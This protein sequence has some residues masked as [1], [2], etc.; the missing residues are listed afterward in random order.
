[1]EKFFIV[2]EKSQLHK[3]Y[4][5]YEQ[6]RKEI[7]ERV[8]KFFNLAGIEA[9]EYYCSSNSLS[10]VPTAKDEEK[11]KGQFYAKSNSNLKTFKAT[12][13]IGK[14]WANYI[15]GYKVLSRPLPQFYF[16]ILSKAQYRL[17]DID[18]I[19]Y[20]SYASKYD[21]KTP[22]GFEEIKGSEF[23]KAIEDWEDKHNA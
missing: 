14:A 8:I 5:E 18:N 1:M 20:C 11:F 22:Q 19:L 13:G 7:N 15:A 10:I 4:F 2:T 21:F 17:F 3:D 9:N 23:F 6:N 16:D 12:S